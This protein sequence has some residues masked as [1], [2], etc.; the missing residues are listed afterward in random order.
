MVR[1]IERVG[2]RKIKI[3][4]FK[5]MILESNIFCLHLAVWGTFNDL[6][7]CKG[8]G[9]SIEDEQLLSVNEKLKT[10]SNDKILLV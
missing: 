2:L 7:I 9:H 1:I 8:N 6:L 3:G 4:L 5:R 10:I